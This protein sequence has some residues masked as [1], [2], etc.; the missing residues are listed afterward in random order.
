MF[1]FAQWDSSN[2]ETLKAMS[3]SSA[4]ITPSLKIR[5]KRKTN[6]EQ[7]GSKKQSPKM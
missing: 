5:T 2:I 7:P 1:I 4:W 3:P 6:M